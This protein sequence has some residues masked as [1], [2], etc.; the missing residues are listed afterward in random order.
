MSPLLDSASMVKGE[1]G[2]V[3]TSLKSVV[4]LLVLASMAY[5]RAS[6]GT[7]ISIPPFDV[8]ATTRSGT[9][10]GKSPCPPLSCSPRGGA[11][12]GKGSCPPFRGRGGKGLE[13]I[14]LRADASTE[15]LLKPLRAEG[16][17]R[18]A[19]GTVP[20]VRPLQDQRPYRSTSGDSSIRV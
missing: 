6:A 9:E 11:E 4:P 5:A 1:S 13:S 16:E 20:N 18:G 3:A 14:K 12:W 15:A 10:W 2:S 8:S 17:T 19:V 7:T